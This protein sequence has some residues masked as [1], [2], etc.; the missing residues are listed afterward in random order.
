[1]TPLP[2]MSSVNRAIRIGV[3]AAV[4]IAL[5]AC[6]RSGGDDDGDRGERAAQTT[7]TTVATPPLTATTPI[8]PTGVGPLRVGADE[9]AFLAEGG[10]AKTIGGDAEAGYGCVLRE[11]LGPAL[12][13]LSY[14]LDA[15]AGTVVAIYLS[16][17][18][19]RPTSTGLRVGDGRDAVTALDRSRYRVDE[20]LPF[21]DDGRLF[22]VRAAAAA[23][24][25]DEPALAVVVKGSRVARFTAG[26]ARWL[27]L[28]PEVQVENCRPEE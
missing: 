13:D 21:E 16:P 14:M 25:P 12:A 4:L 18:S 24:G 6:T 1:M 9:T 28:E 8:E 11:L 2:G 17:T 23:A 7:T 20:E 26:Q 5:A 22:V 15:K 27:A 19:A 3:A 10:A